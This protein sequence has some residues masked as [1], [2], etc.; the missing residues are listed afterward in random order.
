M[1]RVKTLLAPPTSAT[2]RLRYR[3]VVSSAVAVLLAGCGP[4]ASDE[5][6]P[7]PVETTAADPANPFAAAETTMK[8]RMA[9]A[10]GGDVSDTWLKQ[11][12][13]HH[14]G[15][16]DMARIMLQGEPSDHVRQMAQETV[17]KQGAEVDRL[18]AMLGTAPADPA[19][20]APF[21][22][23]RAAMEHAM[24]PAK[25]ADPEETFLRKMLEHHR[26]AVALSD[27]LIAEGGR[28]A[29]LDA[30]RK[31]RTEQAREVGMIGDMLAGK[32]MAAATQ[33]PPPAAG[34]AS[35]PTSRATAAASRAAT[36][37][38]SAPSPA[39]KPTPTPTPEAP[40]ADPHAGH[41]MSQGN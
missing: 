12:I 35:T 30:A 3:L 20:D 24:M 16:I 7:T 21:R 28:A 8:E 31:T 37:A 29:V 23:P 36:R 34:P 25:A 33:P 19:S 11:M 6:A 4:D 5:A 32:P 22:A 18:T 40:A 9:S 27:A 10:I 2:S 38:A 17:E 26:G 39:P 13:E 15:A 1:T 14:R 41:T